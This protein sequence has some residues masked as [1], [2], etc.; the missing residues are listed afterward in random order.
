MINLAIPHP[1]AN[2]VDIYLDILFKVITARVL[3]DTE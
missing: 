2:L 3:I 1:L